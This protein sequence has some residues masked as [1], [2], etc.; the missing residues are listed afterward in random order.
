VG[1]DRHCEDAARREQTKC[2]VRGVREAAPQ[3][4]GQI[5]SVHSA[6]ERHAAEETLVHV[7]TVL[8]NFVDKRNESQEAIG[9]V[10]LALAVSHGARVVGARPMVEFLENW[11]DPGRRADMLAEADRLIRRDK[12]R[13]ARTDKIKQIWELESWGHAEWA[14]QAMAE[15]AFAMAINVQHVLDP[16]E[17]GGNV[18]GYR[19]RRAPNGLLLVPSDSDDDIFVAAKVMVEKDGSGGAQ[20]ALLGWLRGSE[21]KLPQFHHK[22]CWVIPPEALHDMEQLLG[23]ERLQA[24]PPSQDP[25]GGSGVTGR[26]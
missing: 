26:S 23:K 16:K 15:M 9:R 14:E 12:R 8:W 3:S 21:G 1:D 11:S 6:F 19:V 24:V 22:N 10:F 13:T 4:P 7:R 20:C 2:T 18:A 5:P 25:P 17:L